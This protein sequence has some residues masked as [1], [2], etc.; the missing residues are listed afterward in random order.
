MQWQTAKYRSNP[1]R[2]L[3]A[4]RRKIEMFT[5]VQSGDDTWLAGNSQRRNLATPESH[6]SGYWTADPDAIIEKV[7]RG[8]EALN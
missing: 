5:V 2:S 4:C 1:H 3:D 6:H 7:R 8:K